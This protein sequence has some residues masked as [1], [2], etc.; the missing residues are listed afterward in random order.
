[1]E[2][3][4]LILSALWIATMFTYHQGDVMRI[5][6]GD[7]VTGEIGGMQVTQVMWLGIAIL[8]VIP[9]VMVFLSMT[10]PY[11]IKTKFLNHGLPWKIKPSIITDEII[12]SFSKTLVLKDEI[13]GFKFLYDAFSIDRYYECRSGKKGKGKV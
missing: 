13:D 3:V 12:L 5:Y 4:K 7:F 11:S 1:M 2:D 10:L 9:A 6:A 8:M